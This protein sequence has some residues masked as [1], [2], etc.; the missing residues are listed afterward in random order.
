MLKKTLKYLSEPKSKIGLVHGF[1][2]CIGSF[3][4]SFLIISSLPIIT[5][6]D[7]AYKIIPWMMLT[8]IV[9]TILGTWILFSNSYFEIIKKLFYLLLTYLIIVFIRGVI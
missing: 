3:V 7:Y 1:V 2:A 5:K 6:G 4:F 9:I 8:P